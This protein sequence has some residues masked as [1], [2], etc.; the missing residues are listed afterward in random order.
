M[1]AR[2]SI[3]RTVATPLRLIQRAVGS[4]EN[5]QEADAR[6]EELLRPI[7]ERL[8][9]LQQRLQERVRSVAKEAVSDGVQPLQERLERLEREIALLRTSLEAG[10]QPAPTPSPGAKDAP[11]G[12][13]G[14]ASGATGP[15]AKRATKTTSKK[16][17]KSASKG[18]T[19]GAS[20][21]A[22]GKNTSA[23]GTSGSST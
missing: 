16:T 13:S 20:G 18:T 10:D 17:A 8:D 14:Q 2:D 5:G 6:R 11:A 21:A 7:T 19:K 9:Q 15:A 1:N 3:Q 4:D 12:T 23:R 22:G